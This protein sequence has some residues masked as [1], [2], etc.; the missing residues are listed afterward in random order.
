MNRLKDL[1]EERDL[2]QNYLASYLGKS[3]VA[4]SQYETEL[5]NISNVFLKK[6][7]DFYDTSIDY[8]LYRTDDRLPYKRIKDN[9][10]GNANNLKVLRLSFN[11]TQR[12]V[13]MELNIPLKTYIKYENSTIKLNVQLL[14]KFAD[15]FNTSVDYIIGNTNEIK[16]HKK[17]IVNW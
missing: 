11:K 8:I 9:N 16:P 5:Y 13:A 2:N 1:R 3:Q 7:S 10:Y 6:L 12:A 4:Y 17:S 14:N 15:Y